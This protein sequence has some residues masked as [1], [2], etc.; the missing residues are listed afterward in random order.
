MG[1]I[2][3][4]CSDDQINFLIK[5]S[6]STFLEDFKCHFFDNS[7]DFIQYLNFELPSINIIYHEDENTSP[8]KAVKAMK[9]DPWLHF[10]GTLILF[11]NRD[12]K[13]IIDEL[14]GINIIS[15]IPFSRL[16]FNLP[17]A[18]KIIGENRWF[19]FQRDIHSLLQ[20]S[21]SGQFILH[22]DPFDLIT[23]SNL[24]ANFLYNSSLLD[25]EGKEGFYL[26]L[27]ELFMNAIE[28]G[29]CSISFKEKSNCLNND[30]NIFELI[31][32][33]NEDPEIGN[34]TVIFKYRIT[35]KRSSFT[36]RDEGDGFDWR[37]YK[38]TTGES[39]L[40]ERHGRGIIMAEYYLKNLSYNDKGNEVKF[41]VEH[42]P[43][44]SN[45]IPTFF[46]EKDEVDFNKDEIVF[47]QGDESNYLF[48]IVSGTYEIIANG[49]KI[50]VL[51]PADLF[52]GEMSFLLNNKRSATVQVIE[53]GVLL[54]ITKE[55]FI[56]AMK[57]KPYYGILLS[58]ILAHRLVSLHEKKSKNI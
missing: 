54:K 35:P 12:E 38:S 10:G 17:R 2:A 31:N 14:K 50:S 9:D 21:I 24:I 43:L 27:M 53:N 23:Y 18:F 28:H 45:E 1:N 22:N 57:K 39:G 55:R 32:K 20:S 16:E 34:R 46:S 4:L 26:A 25:S 5:N 44:K 47:N 15:F 42:T 40:E 11:N 7:K 19:L 13:K 41:K 37:S 51:T 8:E 48:Y 49:K 36:I 56:N 33:K 52:L 3:V 6:C 30:G 58:R 29:N